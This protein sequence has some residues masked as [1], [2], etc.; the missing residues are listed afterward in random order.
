MSSSDFMQYDTSRSFI[1]GFLL[2]GGTNF[3]G[4][5]DAWV[6]DGPVASTSQENFFSQIGNVLY[7]S[8]FSLCKGMIDLPANTVYQIQCSCSDEVVDHCLHYYQK[9]YANGAVAGDATNVG[10]FL[11]PG[12]GGFFTGEPNIAMNASYSDPMIKVP[13]VD[14]YNPT[15][16][17]P[18]EWGRYDDVT[19]EDALLVWATEESFAVINA[20]GGSTDSEMYKIHWVADTET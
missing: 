15:D 9:S 18:G 3:Q 17:T 19:S 2:S 11:S 6:A 14:F 12:L 20:P 4:A 1:V 13:Q 5:P 7:L 16:G 8:D 10:A